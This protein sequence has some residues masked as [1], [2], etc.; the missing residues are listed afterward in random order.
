VAG[1]G[2]G[3]TGTGGLCPASG[4]AGTERVFVF[5]GNQT[6]GR[7]G[8]SGGGKGEK[9]ELGAGGPTRGLN[10]STRGRA[11]QSRA[12]PNSHQPAPVV[13]FLG[14]AGVGKQKL[15]R[16]VEKALFEK[17]MAAYMLDGTNILLGVDADLVWVQSTQQELVRRFAEVAHI[18]LD[19]GHLVVSTTNSI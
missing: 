10:L 6:G 13:M 1:C 19:A 17:G 14:K 3:K 4:R 8:F 9:G 12:T 5:A 7:G 18:L 11:R 15:A 2:P 16:A